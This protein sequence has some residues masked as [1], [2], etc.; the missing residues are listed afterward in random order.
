[1]AFLFPP[2]NFLSELPLVESNWKPED[3]GALHR[4]ALQGREQGGCVG[5]LWLH[6]KLPQI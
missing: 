4:S 1:M 2:T 5:F 6:N 3:S